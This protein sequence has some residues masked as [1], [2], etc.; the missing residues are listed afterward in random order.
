MIEQ[1]VILDFGSQSTQERAR[2]GLETTDKLVHDHPYRSAGIAFGVGV[3]LG[4]LLTRR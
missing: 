1:I 3:L 2:A 4:V